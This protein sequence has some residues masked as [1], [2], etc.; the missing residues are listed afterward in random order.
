MSPLR[1]QVHYSDANLTSGKLD[2]FREGQAALLDILL[3]S[4]GDFYVGKFTSNIDRIAFALMVA[5][6]GGLVPY[7][8]LDS[9]WCFDHGVQAGYSQHGK[10]LC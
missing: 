5:K 2:A 3:L 6:K 8:S 7:V 1:L 9:T 4:E 10:F